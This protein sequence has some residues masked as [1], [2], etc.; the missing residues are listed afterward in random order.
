MIA[1]APRISARS[2]RP[3]IC[4][5]AA[6]F[7]LAGEFDATPVKLGGIDLFFRT[8][9]FES[10]GRP[11]HV[12]F[13][14]WEDRKD[15]GEIPGP[16]REWTREDRWRAV[17]MKKRRLGQQVLEVVTDGF[18]NEMDARA[19]FEKHIAPL[20]RPDPAVGVTSPGG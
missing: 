2:H 18:S 8:Y 15:P 9:R 11:V 7:K 5:P 17:M 19:A 12:F 16:M 4:L 6:G 20:L 13:C 1:D 10:Q 3:E 14:V